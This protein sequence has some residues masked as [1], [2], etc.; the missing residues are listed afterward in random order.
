MELRLRP[1][2]ICPGNAITVVCNLTWTSIDTLRWD[3]DPNG[4]DPQT[5]F[6]WKDGSHLFGTISNVG[7]IRIISKTSICNVSRLEVPE[8]QGQIPMT[9]TCGDGLAESEHHHI[10]QFTG[11]KY[12]P[13]K[14]NNEEIWIICQIMS[15]RHL[16]MLAF[17]NIPEKKWWLLYSPL[18]VS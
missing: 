15:Q 12:M 6:L 14:K 18:A 2:S 5:V 13:R 8:S 4:V 3:V 17:L 11:N 7:V 10:I 1:S 16:A 9:V